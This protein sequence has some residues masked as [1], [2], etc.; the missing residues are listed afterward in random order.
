MKQALHGVR[1][2]A[3]DVGKQDIFWP[4]RQARSGLHLCVHFSKTSMNHPLRWK[5]VSS[6]CAYAPRDEMRAALTGIYTLQIR[7]VLER[8][9]SRASQLRQ[10]V[11]LPMVRAYRCLR[12][13]SAPLSP[14]STRPTRHFAGRFM[15]RSEG[16][17]FVGL[18]QACC[19]P[20]YMQV[21]AMLAAAY[22]H[23]LTIRACRHCVRDCGFHRAATCLLAI[24]PSKRR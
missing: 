7:S 23:A 21:R 11:R 14:P 9:R 12:R 8:R 1:E 4:Q 2:R 18:L 6:V 15:C 17:T 5:G 20:A 16:C 13:T 19:A 10:I 3:L 22:C 24:A